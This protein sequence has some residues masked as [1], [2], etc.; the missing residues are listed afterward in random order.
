MDPGRSDGPADGVR[1]AP[2]HATSTAP[3]T[4]GTPA[5]RAIGGRSQTVQRRFDI[6][7]SAAS[8]RQ[9]GATTTASSASALHPRSTG[10]LLLLTCGLFRGARLPPSSPD[11][12]L[13]GREAGV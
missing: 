4:T 1:R 6:S 9:E 10:Y 12:T 11:D 3:R 13:Q 2:E 8:C 7:T 5:T